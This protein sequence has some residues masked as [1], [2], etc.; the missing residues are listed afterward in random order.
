MFCCILVTNALNI[1]SNIT[2]Q[3]QCLEESK[4]I[5]KRPPRINLQYKNKDIVLG[6]YICVLC[7]IL[8]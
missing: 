8:T 7:I 2:C 3:V 4:T 6:L 1:L 5:S